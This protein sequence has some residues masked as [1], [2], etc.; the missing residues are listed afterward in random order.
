MAGKAGFLFRG[1]IPAEQTRLPLEAYQRA[2]QQRKVPWSPL[3]GEILSLLWRSG[4]AW[5][6]YDIARALSR[7]GA[8]AHPNSVYR[9]LRSL[10]AAGLVVPI[11]TWNRYLLSPDPEIGS[12]CVILCSECRRF[13][14]TAMDD[15][16]ERLRTLA[17]ARGFRPER[18]TIECLA[19]CEACCG[20]GLIEPRREHLVADDSGAR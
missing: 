10:D 14:V 9:A 2:V 8:R 13:A 12:W 20:G 6:P 18:A 11:L 3:R 16:V 15:A 1:A 19:R 17:R 7:E 5:G 4:A